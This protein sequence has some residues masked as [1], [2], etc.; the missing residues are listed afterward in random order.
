MI[1]GKQNDKKN[2]KTFEYYLITYDDTKRIHDHSCHLG[3]ETLDLTQHYDDYAPKS[4]N[5]E[6]FSVQVYGDEADITAGEDGWFFDGDYPGA[7]ATISAMNGETITKI[8][9]HRSDYDNTLIVKAD[10]NTIPYSQN[11]DDLT[12]DN[13]NA[14]SVKLSADPD[15]PDD[16]YCDVSSIDVY[17]TGG[18]DPA[19]TYTLTCTDA[20]ID[21]F[22]V[23]V[24]P[25]FFDVEKDNWDVYAERGV[26]YNILSNPDHDEYAVAF[27]VIVP[28]GTAFNASDIIVT[29][30]DTVLTLGEVGDINTDKDVVVDLVNYSTYDRYTYLIRKGE[31]TDNIVADY[32]PTYTVTW[33]NYD[34]SVLETDAD[35]AEGATPEYNGNEPTKAEDDY[36]TY[37]F[38]GWS[39]EVTAVTDDVEYAATFDA[40]P[41][42]VDTTKYRLTIASSGGSGTKSTTLPCFLSYTEWLGLARLWEYDPVPDATVADGDEEY[43]SLE[44][45]NLKILKPFTGTKTINNVLEQHYTVTV[46]CELDVYSITDESVNGTVTASVNDTDVTEAAPDDAVLLNVAPAEGYHFKSITAT[47]AKNGVEDFSDLVDLMGDAVADGY[48]GEFDGYTFKVEDG[49]F[50]IYNGSTLFAELSESDVSDF[51]V[52]NGIYAASGDEGWYFTLSDNKI[53]EF[54]WQND[55]TYDYFFTNKFESTGTLPLVELALTTVTE[56]SQ[57]SFTM[58]KNP[59]TVTAEFEE[60]PAPTPEDDENTYEFAGWTPDIAEVTA[61]AEYTATFTATGKYVAVAEMINALPAEVT[62]NDAQAITAA[63]EAYNNLTNDQKALI[64]ADTLAKLE[65]AEKMI[66][67]LNAAAE[68]TAMINAL[69]DPQ[70]VTVNDKDQIKAASDAYTALTSDQTKLVGEEVFNRL[71]DVAYAYALAVKAAEDQAAA[72]D[73][74]VMINNLPAE[75]TANDA[76]AITAA[77]EAYDDL[78][79]DQKA[80]I[81]ADTLAKLEA[82]EAAL[83]AATRTY[84]KVNAN[85]A[86]CTANGNIEY[87]VGSDGKFYSD[88]QG[89]PLADLNNDGVVDINDTIIPATPHEYVE[90]IVQPKNGE[91]GYLLHTCSNCN[92]SYKDN[93]FNDPLK[94]TSR[95]ETEGKVGETVN[96][97]GAAEGGVAGYTYAF[98]YRKITTGTWTK[99]GKKYGTATSAKFT[100]G[101]ATV[102]EVMINVKDSIGKVKSKTFTIDLRTE[103]TNETTV[104]AE[105]ITLGEKIVL[106]G[107][108]SGGTVTPTNGYKYAFYYKKSRNTD[109]IEM[110]PAYTTKSASVRPKTAQ[111][112]DVKSVVMDAEGNTNEV[113]YT[114]NVTK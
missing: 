108:A 30:G 33:K 101:K 79:S 8:V 60:A 38:A 14:S 53:T 74:T 21:A 105:T 81:D 19:P 11:G 49:K 78:T 43:L 52:G 98:M 51:R 114:V 95:I 85:D 68:V 76:Q 80:L 58:P 88:D 48:D 32:A 97:Y 91:Q 26:A 34:G 112:Y 99:I 47:C 18:S 9:V 42:V 66:A 37:S 106:K 56:G 110:K 35:V 12:Y 102:Y 62:A 50:V 77:R 71:V 73:V 24:T 54:Y 111:S 75:V 104:N 103:L 59:V 61:D 20:L 96:L 109:W 72:D 100:P 83:E 70:N 7:Y 87:Y 13:I 23:N 36:F 84:D 113:T 41:K 1:G 39:P 67:D 86:S 45:S 64:D 27:S 82:A 15:Y 25:Q 69:P 90:T 40:T 17:Y 107:A 94:N 28:N 6:R 2:K 4:F 16:S 65:A 55:T 57:Y 93:Y 63:R 31:L 29:M 46:T 92:D 5:G 89:T 3:V 44:D 10:D 22:D